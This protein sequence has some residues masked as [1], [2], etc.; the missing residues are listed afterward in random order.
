MLVFLGITHADTPQ[1]CD[2][3]AKKVASIR[4]FDDDTGRMNRSLADVGGSILCVS[5]FT[6]YAD[7]R[8]GN[9]PSF[10]DAAAGPEAEHLY[11]R[12]CDQVRRQGVACETGT[13]GAKMSVELLNDGP[14]TL[15]LDSDELQRPRRT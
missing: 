3:M 10:T 4:L 8:R 6:L 11:D 14:A 13:F 12:F 7:A 15:W 5:Q 1:V 9:R 2:A